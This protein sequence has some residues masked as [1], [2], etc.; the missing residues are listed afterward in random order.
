MSPGKV[1]RDQ[2]KQLTD[3]PNIGKAGAADLQLLG[4]NTPA[5]LLGKCP[6]QLYEQLC[7]KTGV[8]HDPCV[9]D[10][11]LSITTFMAGEAPR[12]WWD[13]TALR[14]ATFTPS[15]Q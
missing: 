4:I 13:F 8:R 2:L 6:Y 12:P 14:K 1:N 7:V 3:R 15:N 11:F 9:L 10:V 5:H